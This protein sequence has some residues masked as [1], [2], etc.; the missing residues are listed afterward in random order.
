MAVCGSTFW[1]S[2]FAGRSSVNVC[3]SENKNK[4]DVTLSPFVD[5]KLWAALSENQ[6]F[7]PIIMCSVHS[8]FCDT[9]H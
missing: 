2:L 1:G 5:Q 4:S 7:Q 8:A 9:L 6:F 3:D